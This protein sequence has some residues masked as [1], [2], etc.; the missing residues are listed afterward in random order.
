MAGHIAARRDA[1][2]AAIVAAAWELAEQ[3]GVASLSLHA[4]ARAVGMRQPSLYEYFDSKNAL[5]DAMFADGNRQLLAHLEA[6]RLPRDPRS[7]LKTCLGALATFALER[8]SRYELMFLR[9]LPG[10]TPS[11]ESYS[12]AQEVLGRIVTLMHGA[13]VTRQADVDC[14]VAVVAGLIDAQLSNEPTTNRWVRHLNRLV[15][16]VVDDA[17]ARSGAR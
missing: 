13:G 14:L 8:P 1:K 11:S 4:L 12:I 2:I 15:D 16:L 17:I 6:Q 5:Y 3:N 10:F 9:H 7:A